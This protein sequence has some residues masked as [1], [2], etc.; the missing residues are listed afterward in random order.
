[1][2]KNPSNL[3]GLLGFCFGAR[4]DPNINEIACRFK[5]PGNYIHN[6]I[7]AKNLVGSRKPSRHRY[8]VTS[9]R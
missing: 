6:R 8:F 5:S 2:R 1:L 9:I 4:I 3:K 7:G